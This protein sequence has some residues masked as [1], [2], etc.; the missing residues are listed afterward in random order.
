MHYKVTVYLKFLFAYGEGFFFLDKRRNFNEKRRETSGVDKNLT[1]HSK[2]RSGNYKFLMKDSP[3]PLKS[4]SISSTA[5][6]E[7]PL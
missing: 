2:N 4:L 3:F 5:K 7:M 6:L 1:K